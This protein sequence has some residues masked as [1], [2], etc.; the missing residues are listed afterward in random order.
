[1]AAEVKKNKEKSHHFVLV[2]GGGT[3][4]WCW[5]K[6][7]HLLVKEGHTVS[8]I[9]MASAGIHPA[10]PD[11]ITTLED[12]NLPLTSFFEA[13]PS[14][15][16]VIL[17][18]HSSGGFNVSLTMEKFPQKIATAVFVTAFMPLSGTTLSDSMNEVLSKIGRLGDTIF[19]HAKGE[20]NPATS[21]KF[22]SQFSQEFALQK[23]PPW[24]VALISS[25][26]KKAPIWKEALLY[27]KE[28][29]GSVPRAYV[30]AKEDKLMVEEFQRKM[31]AENPPHMIREIEGSDHCPFFCKPEC[32]AQTLIQIANA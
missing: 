10:D 21:F 29:Y 3:G 30:V 32:L 20:E 25:L 9:D 4:A 31:I 24:D 14:E 12:Y 7:N 23:S 26:V 22:G 17:V 15:R 5:Y 28:N 1:M 8:S 19:Y 18:G 2:H 13:L 27:S 6:L 11:T 16:K